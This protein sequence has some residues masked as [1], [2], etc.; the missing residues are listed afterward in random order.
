MHR[1][2]H[3]PQ[4]VPW[5]ARSNSPPPRPRPTPLCRIVAHC[6][7]GRFEWSCCRCRRRAWR[8][9]FCRL[10]ERAH[11][12]HWRARCRCAR[13]YSLTWTRTC[14]CTCTHGVSHTPLSQSTSVPSHPH[15]HVPLPSAVRGC[16][17]AGI[18]RF[19]GDAG[20]AHAYAVGPSE[21]ELASD[22]KVRRFRR[23][24]LCVHASRAAP[25]AS[26]LVSSTPSVRG[27][28]FALLCVQ[29]A[30]A[31]A[32]SRAAVAV[33]T[34]ATEPHGGTQTVPMLVDSGII[35]PP[36]PRPRPKP[37]PLVPAPRSDLSFRGP[38]AC[39]THTW[40]ALRVRVYLPVAVA[41]VLRGR[42]GRNSLLQ[43]LALRVW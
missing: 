22:L 13:G 38:G 17:A 19:L 35:S 41:T 23:L 3:D 7:Y 10:V 33:A 2:T 42:G 37:R 16:A 24:N 34:T 11:A 5:D 28:N 20:S 27:S 25:S 15:S 1:L 31:A 30:S 6:A 4:A 39:F 40:R 12:D 43:G 36:L 18:A 14:T 29:G 32:P 26:C 21:S 9:C 8:R